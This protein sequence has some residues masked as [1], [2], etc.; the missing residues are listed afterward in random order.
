MAY[1][2]A[3]AERIRKTLSRRRGITEKKMFGGLA[4]LHRG[5]MC[6]GV[7]GKDLVVRLGEEGAL[8]ALEKGKGA[9]REMDFTGRPMK[10]MVY[11]GPRGTKTDKRLRDWV[12]KAVDFAKTIPPKLK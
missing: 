8:R 6:C 9:T 1:D 5:N 4:F 10:S 7:V 11:V 12:D 2:E 3:L